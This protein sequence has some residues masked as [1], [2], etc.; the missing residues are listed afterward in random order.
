[1]PNVIGKRLDIELKKA[2]GQINMTI[3]SATYFQDLINDFPVLRADISSEDGDHMKMEH[4]ADY[5]IRQIKKADFVEL[6]KCFDFQENKINNITADLENAMTVSYCE[7]LLLGEVSN[8]MPT[9]VKYMGPKLLKMYK[10]CETH[11]N[12]LKT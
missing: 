11:Y 3:N 5:T 1:M 7:S 4:F 12:N 8:L 6:K 2:F 10:D 9:T